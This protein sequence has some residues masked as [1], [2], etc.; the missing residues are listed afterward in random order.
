MKARILIEHG[1]K[2]YRIGRSRECSS[3]RDCSLFQRGVCSG[4]ETYWANKLPCADLNKAL[5]DATGWV[6]SFGFKE[7]TK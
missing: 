6:C 4:A 7:V 5:F 1:G 3:K 2:T